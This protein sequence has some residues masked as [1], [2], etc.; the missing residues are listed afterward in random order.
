MTNE[1]INDKIM[2]CSWDEIINN[3]FN[4]FMQ[5]I[6]WYQSKVVWLNI[7]LTV[8]GIVTTLQGMATF[9][10]YAQALVLV[11]TIGNII[12]RV[13]FTNTTIATPPTLSV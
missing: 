8:L 7:I 11:G 12:L 2:K 13:W 1:T 5:Q 10:K 9:D 4:K 6:S 3:K